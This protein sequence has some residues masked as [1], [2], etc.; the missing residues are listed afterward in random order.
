MYLP[1]SASVPSMVNVAVRPTFASFSP[2]PRRMTFGWFGVFDLIV[3]GL[4]G[5]IGRLKE[6]LVGTVSNVG[7]VLR[8]GGVIGS[9]VA[10]P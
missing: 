1:E 6:L 2:C 5:V 7:V 9:F 8:G 4:E 3:E 10:Y